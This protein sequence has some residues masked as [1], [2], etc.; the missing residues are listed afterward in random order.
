GGVVIAYNVSGLNTGLKLDG[1]TAAKI[2]LGDIKTWNDPAIAALN[3]G[4]SLPNTP[5]SVVHRSDES[6]TTF[7]YTSWLSSQS[8]DWDTKVGADKAVQW[9]TGTGGDG[10]DGVAAAI[11]QTD[12]SIGY[13]SFDF[14]VSANLGIADIKAADG[15]F[16]TPSIDSISKAG[17]GLTFPIQP[18][19]TILLGAGAPARVRRS[20]LIDRG[21]RGTTLVVGL[22]LIAL[23]ALML[24]ELTTGAWRT[25]DAF[26]LH[27]FVGT[28]WN[29]VSGREDFG[30][31]PFIF[32]SLVTSGVAI[33]IG[34]PIA[35]G[36]ALL[37]NQV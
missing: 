8:K 11:G 21:F 4:V 2:F 34:V 3:P 30:A 35:V 10:N 33:V 18:T 19:T 20:R 6:G 23:L 14:A 36:L 7:V 15:S 5:I 31:L 1:I 17:G 16:I 37:L 29:P 9:P 27:F 12:G 25:F 13:L 28:S 22:G 24:V 32:G 26:G